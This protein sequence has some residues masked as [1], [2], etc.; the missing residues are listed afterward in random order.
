MRLTLASIFR[1][2]AGYLDRY[3]AQVNALRAE[4]YDV[5]LALAE[6]DSTDHTFDRLDELAG[7]DDILVK[8]D[9]GGPNYGSVDRAERWDQI[10][11]VVRGLL[12][13]VDDP[14]D[15]FVWVE[16]DLM[17]D[18]PVMA[19]LLGAEVP[20]VAPMVYAGLS[21]RFYDTWGFRKDGKGFDRFWPHWAGQRPPGQEERLVKIDSCG[22]CFV[23][24]SDAYDSLFAWSGHWPFTADGALWLDTS[25]AVRHP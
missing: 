3:F 23:L 7:A 1:D 16:S 25:V 15:A 4:G 18:W 17:W 6:G 9:H 13:K 8:I 5:R 21:S 10:A 2:S 22:S 11:E 19:T 12:A 20:A 14:G 24:R